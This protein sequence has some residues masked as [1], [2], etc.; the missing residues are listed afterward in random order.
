M[1]NPDILFSPWTLAPLG[2]LVLL[3]GLFMKGACSAFNRAVD[4]NPSASIEAPSFLRALAILVIML[5][6]IAG[7]NWGM[8]S[9]MSRLAAD[10]ME[11]LMSYMPNNHEGEPL[12]TADSVCQAVIATLWMAS[13]LLQYVFCALLMM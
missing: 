13:G 2:I 1:F 9:G 6:F 4:D 5:S 10:D 12:L 3:L 7:A 8:I 11:T